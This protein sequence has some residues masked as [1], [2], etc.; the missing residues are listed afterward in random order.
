MKRRESGL[1]FFYCCFSCWNYCI[2]RLKKDTKTFK[3]KNEEAAGP[4]G[5]GLDGRDTSLKNTVRC[6]WASA[7]PLC[8]LGRK[9]GGATFKKAKKTI[10]SVMLLLKMPEIETETSNAACLS[11]LLSWYGPAHLKGCALWS[12]HKPT[13]LVSPISVSNLVISQ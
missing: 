2:Y 7:M 1:V 8:W 13:P 6:L 3:W 5:V 12:W 11:S 10:K 9:D 4:K